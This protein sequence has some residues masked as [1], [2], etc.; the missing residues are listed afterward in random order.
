MDAILTFNF[1]LNSV[2]KAH[3]ATFEPLIGIEGDVPMSVQ[4][5]YQE[6]VSCLKKITDSLKPNGV[7]AWALAAA[8]ITKIPDC[9]LAT[10]GGFLKV[11]ELNSIHA[12]Q[13]LQQVL[14]RS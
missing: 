11:A 6:Q 1:W 14:G 3:V 5:V 4:E 2:V 13:E 12:V 7:M 9:Q 10:G 8:D